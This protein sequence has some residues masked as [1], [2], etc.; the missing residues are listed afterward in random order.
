MK[1]G[2]VT[3]ILT[4]PWIC[5]MHYLSLSVLLEFAIGSSGF[6]TFFNDRIRSYKIEK[7]VLHL[8]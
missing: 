7:L 5:F 3:C 1:L 4:D 6:P 8:K 2:L